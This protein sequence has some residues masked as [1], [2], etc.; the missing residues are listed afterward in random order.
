MPSNK[1]PSVVQPGPGKLAAGQVPASA[2]AFPFGGAG[3]LNAHINDPID[4]H[5]SGAIGIPELNPT[6]SQPLLSSAG[7]PYDGESVLDALTQLSDLLPLRP[8]KIGFNGTV[9]NSGIPDWTNGLTVGGLGTAVHGGWTDGGGNGIVTQYVAPV[10]EIGVHT[11]SGIVYPADRG[12]LAVYRTTDGDFFNS[13][14]TTLVAALWL[15]PNPPPGGVPGAAFNEAVRPVGQTDYTATGVGLDKITLIDR[16]PYLSNYPGSEYA[17]FSTNFSAYQLG[18]YSF[19]ITL[20]AGDS[21]SYLLVHWKETFATSLASIQPA[22]LTALT[23]VLANCYS[24]VPSHGASYGEVNRKNIFVD[25]DSATGASPVAITATPGGVLTTGTVSGIDFYSSTG[26]TFSILA[27]ANNLFTNAYR[28][29]AVASVSVPTGFTSTT[30]PVQVDMADFGGGTTGYPLYDAGTPHIFDDA[31]PTPFSLVSPP[32]PVTVARYSNASEPINYASLANPFFPYAS[33]RLYWWPSF[34]GAATQ[35]ATEQFLFNP[36]G[37]TNDTATL[38]PFNSEQYRYV[39]NYTAGIAA[40]PLLPAGGDIYP[41]ATL[42]AANDGNLQVLQGYL[43]YPTYNFSVAPWNPTTVG[44]DYAT[45]QAG[46]AANHKRRYVRAFNTGIA[47]NT[48]KLRIT[49]LAFS[50]FDTGLSAIDPAE[51]TDHTGGAIV[52]IKVP[53]ATG[54]LDLGR[55]DG[56][57]DLTKTLDFRGCRTGIA[58]DV[59][60]FDTGSFTSD[61]GS[62]QFLLFVRVTLI[63]NGVGELL[64]VQEIEWLPP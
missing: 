60:T 19:D 52:Q 45:V 50:A 16:L 30:D 28:T 49:G 61:N 14:Q 18:K 64:S 53:G 1:D 37:V 2:I 27:T 11:I 36:I 23:L 25:S 15:G 4:A 56:V 38:E 12:V 47:R 3:D 7:G 26:L 8:D 58:G 20:V 59:Y 40:V 43:V 62:G 57:P 54:W 24:A 41:S 34:G 13:V 51:I 63:K 55:A 46:D 5:M 39:S 42:L 22:N 29:N 48:G 9:P 21:D 17:P 32:T 35:T 6:T 33:I 31:G 44:G 10:G